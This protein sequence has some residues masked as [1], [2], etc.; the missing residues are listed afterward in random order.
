MSNLHYPVFPDVYLPQ[1]RDVLLPKVVPVELSHH[2][3]PAVEDPLAMVD[4][5]LD[6]SR[7]LGALGRGAR[8]GIA[9]GSRGIAMLP[10]VAIRVVAWAKQRGLDPYLI[11]AMGS[12]G[13]AQA[14]T[15]AQILRDLGMTEEVVGA[16]IESSMEVLKLGTTSG[17]VPCYF[18]KAAASM[19]AVLI[20]NRVKS[21]TSFDRPIESGLT[22]MV[23]VGLG[24][25][26]G[27]RYVHRLG[28]WGLRDVLPELARIS[29]SKAPIAFGLALVENSDKQLIRIEGVEPEDFAAADERLLVLAKKNLARLPFDQID[30]L[31][32]EE[33][34]KDISGMG[35][36]YAVIGRTDIRGI[37]NPPRPFIH[38]IVA[39]SVT[40][41]SH[42]NAQGIGVADFIPKRVVESLDLRDLYTNAITAAVIEK[43]RIPPVLPND[44][45]AIA[46]AVATAWRLNED[47]VRLCII[48][49]TLHLKTIL[50][51]EALAEEVGTLDSARIA[52]ESGPITFSDEGTLATRCP[53]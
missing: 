48:R 44:R 50:V 52:G 14:D 39:L 3:S 1:L 40:K 49:S 13:G 19:D 35:M 45:E 11:P 17:G 33:I 46:A 30:V 26:Q 41:A 20:I 6:R 21:H 5:E 10:E 29:L 24:K 42:G 51:S 36:D 32:V 43:T 47:E 31:I 4:A 37:P 34:G 38:K 18:S 2:T 12:H 23:A 8:L 22:K 27:A 16:P 15:Q 7:R 9:L 28:P 25:A 53:R